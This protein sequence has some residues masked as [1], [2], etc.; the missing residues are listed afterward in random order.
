MVRKSKL[1]EYFD[2]SFINKID[3][4]ITEIYHLF[5]HLLRSIVQIVQTSTSSHLS[6]TLFLPMDIHFMVLWMFYMY[7]CAVVGK[8]IAHVF[9]CCFKIENDMFDWKCSWY[10]YT[11]SKAGCRQKRYI[12]LI[13]NSAIS[14]GEIEHKYG[15]FLTSQICL[16]FLFMTS[17]L[18]HCSHGNSHDTCMFLSWDGCKTFGVMSLK[19]KSRQ[20][21]LFII[22]LTLWLYYVKEGFF[23]WCNTQMRM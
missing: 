20:L 21:V 17:S 14:E 4:Q 10:I 9:F 15:T 13:F 5:L 3:N 18:K 12:A 23:N 11:I 22:V 6:N 8:L 7:E 1:H 19:M 2:N 16:N